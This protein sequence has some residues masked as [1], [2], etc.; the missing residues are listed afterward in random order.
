MNMTLRRGIMRIMQS[1]SELDPP[2][3]IQYAALPYRQRQDGEVQIRLITSRETRRWVI[4]KGW[5]MKGLPPH[6][7]AEREAFE[8]A[9]LLGSISPTSIGLYTYEKRLSVK[10]SVTCDV[11]V[12]PMKVKRYL[13]KWPER[14]Q[15]IGFWFTIEGAAAAVQEE[16][17]RDL[18]LRFGVTMA[19][20]FA[21]KGEKTAMTED[22]RPA[23]K[24]A[25]KDRKAP[26][27]DIAAKAPSAKAKKDDAGLRAAKSKVSAATS[28]AAESVAAA[29][30][31]K[32]ASAKKAETK[33]ATKKAAAPEKAPPA[34]KAAAG[35]AAKPAEGGALAADPKSKAAPVPTK[36]S[37]ASK[38]AASQKKPAKAKKSAKAELSAGGDLAMPRTTH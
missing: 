19:V 31:V 14:T 13:K 3:R 32:K 10:R 34:K 16:E 1:V 26:S 17:L 24:P 36:K 6:K 35:K 38:K 9:G 27:K 18:I 11:M 33:A 2:R 5:P 30:L 25:A 4:P 22:A 12:F 23:D 37:G 28:D 29:H 7:A 21:A 15:R 8:E 20:R